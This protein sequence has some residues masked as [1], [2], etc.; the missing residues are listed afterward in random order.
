MF[1]EFQRDS[2]A[3]YSTSLK[4]GVFLTL[5]TRSSQLI[6]ISWHRFVHKIGCLREV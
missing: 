5:E 1:S 2:G 6:E 4:S 3:G